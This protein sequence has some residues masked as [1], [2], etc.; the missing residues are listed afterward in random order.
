MRIVISWSR[1]P[2]EPRSGLDVGC[3]R[4][5]G[6]HAAALL[7]APLLL[8]CATATPVPVCPS[9]AELKPLAEPSCTLEAASATHT[10]LA[11]RFEP[12]AGP[13]LVRIEF[14]SQS[15]P[16]NVCVERRY[17]A[18]E[19]R[20]LRHI[21]TEIAALSDIAPGP[22][23]LADRRLDLNRRNASLAEMERSWQKCEDR[24]R[25][26][27]QGITIG[28]PAKIA[29]R[30]FVQCVQ[31]ESKVLAVEPADGADALI[32]AAPETL[33]PPDLEPSRTAERC[34]DAPDLDELI[35]CIENDGW[36]LVF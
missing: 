20:A 23:C 32:F 1:R 16:G 34:E 22:P 6:I 7:T 30:E 3:L 35:S 2:G 18:G 15:V 28:S 31:F 11:D 24:Y 9:L 8:A 4:P 25:S 13:L 27:S 19:A 14:D 36:E 5:L 21:R 26:A 33:D 12:A 17:N 29:A 10:S